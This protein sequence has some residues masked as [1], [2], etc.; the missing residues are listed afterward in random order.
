[1]KIF[2]YRALMIVT[3]VKRKSVLIIWIACGLIILV[4]G[5]LDCCLVP[6]Y[7]DGFKIIDSKKAYDFFCLFQIL[8]Y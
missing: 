4:R 3:S 6:F 7:I 5:C 2:Q 1:M 8:E